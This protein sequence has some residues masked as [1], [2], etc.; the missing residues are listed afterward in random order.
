MFWKRMGNEKKI[1]AHIF[2][3]RSEDDLTMCISVVLS[4]WRKYEREKKKTIE[5]RVA[6]TRGV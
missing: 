1:V 3:K 4:K 6:P 5:S 2:S